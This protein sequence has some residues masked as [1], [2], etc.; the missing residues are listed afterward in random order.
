MKTILCILALSIAMLVWHA[1][2]TIDDLPDHN[3]ENEKFMCDFRIDVFKN[4]KKVFREDGFTY[5]DIIVADLCAK[6]VYTYCHND[7]RYTHAQLDELTGQTYE[8][9]RKSPQSE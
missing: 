9:P 5:D 4:A 6:D 1:A 2:R 8:I 7:A 3:F